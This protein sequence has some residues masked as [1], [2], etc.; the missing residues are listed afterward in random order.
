MINPPVVGFT[1]FP[2]FRRL[3]AAASRCIFSIFFD[4]RQ[5]QVDPNFQFFSTCG[6][7]KS[8]HFLIFYDLRQPQVGP[9]R[10]LRHDH[11]PGES[12]FSFFSTC[13]SRKSAKNR[14]CIASRDLGRLEAAASRKKRKIGLTCGCRKWKKMEKL[15]QLDTT[16]LRENPTFRRRSGFW[17]NCGCRKSK[18]TK[19]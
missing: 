16:T 13:G 17:Q 19:I 1:L 10:D 5:P 3:A 15:H 2:Y 9:N 14:T 8:T 6:S 7:R 12:N 18:K 4:L 11:T